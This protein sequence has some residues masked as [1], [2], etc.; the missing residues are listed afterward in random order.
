MEKTVSIKMR[1]TAELREGIDRIIS[2]REEMGHQIQRV[3][4][5]RDGDFVT[6]DLTFVVPVQ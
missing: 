4:M 1:T 2:A 3:S 5:R 6:A